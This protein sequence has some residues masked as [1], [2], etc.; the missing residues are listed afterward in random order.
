MADDDGD[1]RALVDRFKAYRD[2][3]GLDYP[4]HVIEVAI[5]ECT[6]EM[7]EESRELL[8]EAG[9]IISGQRQPDPGS[10]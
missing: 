9:E 2:A 3:R 10:D 6:G 5:A 8:V 1:V 4:D 7:D